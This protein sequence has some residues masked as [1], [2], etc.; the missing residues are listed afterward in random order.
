MVAQPPPRPPSPPRPGSWALSLPEAE[1]AIAGVQLEHSDTPQASA[2]VASTSEP[3]SSAVATAHVPVDFGPAGVEDLG[4]DDEKAPTLPTGAVSV[5]QAE[6]LLAAKR[7]CGGCCPRCGALLKFFAVT[8][9]ALGL[10]NPVGRLTPVPASVVVGCVLLAVAL[11]A[12]GIEAK[13]SWRGGPSEPAGVVGCARRARLRGSLSNPAAAAQPPRSHCWTGGSW[14]S[15]TVLCPLIGYFLFLPPLWFAVRVATYPGQYIPKL[16]RRD[17]PEHSSAFSFVSRLDG[18]VLLAGRKV[19]RPSN[20]TDSTSGGRT[21]PLI[22]L[23]GNG[24]NVWFNLQVSSSPS[25]RHAPNHDPPCRP[26]VHHRPSPCR[27]SVLRIP[28][29]LRD[30]GAPEIDRHLL[31]SRSGGRRAREAVY[32]PGVKQRR[33]FI[34]GLLVLL[35]WLLPEW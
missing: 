22:F 14:C 25:I 35:P 31:S 16:N 2:T 21:V 18:A 13:H 19:F 4:H 34:R 3:E 33:A 6:T 12:L 32:R 11:L 27:P 17:P 5:E 29:D 23:G 8:L 7:C 26:S 28:I 30:L 20:F 15:R 9:F 1:V 24:G 10:A